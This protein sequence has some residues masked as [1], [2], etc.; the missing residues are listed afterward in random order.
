MEEKSINPLSVVSLVAGIL[1]IVGHMCCC[2]P[3]IGVFFGILVMIL[4]VVA[5]VTGFIARSQA[6]EG[7]SEPL[8]LAG[9]ATGAGAA[10]ISIIWILLTVFV[11]GLSAV[12][13]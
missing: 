1:A 12:T 13:G 6:E 4:E 11:V 2:V 5:I 10:V 9:I 8:A 7:Q 3:F